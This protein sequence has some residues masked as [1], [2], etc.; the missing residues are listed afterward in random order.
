MA[1]VVALRK[2]ANNFFLARATMVV[3]I[4]SIDDNQKTWKEQTKNMV[5]RARCTIEWR[6]VDHFSL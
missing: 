2:V 4:L 5:G 1:L 3:A 6:I